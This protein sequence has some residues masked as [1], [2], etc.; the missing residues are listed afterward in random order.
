MEWFIKSVIF[1]Y[2]TFNTIRVF[3]YVPQI[4]AVSKDT[5]PAKG[6]SLLTW[7]FW[8]VAN[9]TTGLYATVVLPDMLLAIMSYG[10]T[11]GCAIVVSIVIYK[12][13]KYGNSFVNFKANKEYK[14][15]DDED[16]INLFVK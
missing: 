2:F 11:L 15:A 10:N 6:I 7:S 13:N 4:I 3:S 12:R 8:V 14:S 1:M 5:T 16:V 9:L